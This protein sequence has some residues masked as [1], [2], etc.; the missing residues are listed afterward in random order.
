MDD[1]RQHFR[2]KRPCKNCPFRREGGVPLHPKR[3]EGIIHDLLSDDMATFQ[4]H[5]TVE[6]ANS[7]CWSEDGRYTPTGR[8]AMCA[9]AAALLWQRGMPNVAMR[10]GILTGTLNIADLEEIQAEIIA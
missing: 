6:Y 10:L 3:L 2:L 7:A 1:L 8:E 9:G 4:C 5:K